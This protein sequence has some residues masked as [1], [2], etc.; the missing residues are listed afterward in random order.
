MKAECENCGKRGHIETVCRAHEGARKTGFSEV[1]FTA[2]QNGTQS[3]V[4]IVDSG[5]TQH[6]TADRS[7]F[8][9]Y[10]K[11]VTSGKIKGIGD[12]PYCSGNR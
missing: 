4:W 10:K 2:W 5:S 9:S 8:T 6:I 7:E 3:E 11:L 12:Q 1:A